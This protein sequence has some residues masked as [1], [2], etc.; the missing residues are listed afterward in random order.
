MPSGGLSGASSSVSNSFTCLHPPQ[1]KSNNNNNNNNNILI[2]NNI[3]RD[4]NKFIVTISKT[5]NISNG[6]NRPYFIG[7]FDSEEEANHALKKV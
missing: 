2:N 3:T 1:I 5:Q 6:L 7:K 4:R